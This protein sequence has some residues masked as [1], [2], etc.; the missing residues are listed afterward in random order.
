MTSDVYSTEAVRDVA[1]DKR[2]CYFY[3][4]RPLDF[5]KNYSRLPRKY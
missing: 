2:F 5:Y 3:D 1:V 4:E